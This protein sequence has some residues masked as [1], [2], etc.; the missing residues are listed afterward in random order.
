MSPRI[1]KH[2]SAAA[3][4]G[5]GLSL[6]FAAPTYAQGASCGVNGATLFTAGYTCTAGDKIYSEFTVLQG[7]AT[8][9]GATNFF[10]ISDNNPSHTLSSVGNYGVGTYAFSYKMEIIP[11]SL[12]FREFGSIKTSASTSIIPPPPNTWTKTLSAVPA[13]VPG[14]V[15]STEASPGGESTLAAFPNGI[16]SAVFTST[17]NVTSGI[18]TGFSDSTTQDVI[19]DV[20][21]PLPIFGAGMAFGFS[22]KLRRRVSAAS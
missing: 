9:A 18:V 11:A 13:T 2:A 15:I 5:A 8:L 20:P 10:I 19:N 3:L 16:K 17:L 7:G 22:R 14:S 12:P 6:G 1:L 4:V 21:G